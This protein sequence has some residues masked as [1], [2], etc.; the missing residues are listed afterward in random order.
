VDRFCILGPIEQ[1]LARLTQLRELGV[2]QFA[3]YLQHDDK[4]RTLAAYGEHVIPALSP[5]GAA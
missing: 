5:V 3:V 2:D 1:H 4:E